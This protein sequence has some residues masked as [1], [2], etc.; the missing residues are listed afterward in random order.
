MGNG[1]IV[2][3]PISAMV[4]IPL[5]HVLVVY[6][7]Q[8]YRLAEPCYCCEHLT[9]VLLKLKLTFNHGQLWRSEKAFNGVSHDAV[10]WNE[11][12]S[13]QF[14]TIAKNLKCFWKIES[15]KHFFDFKEKVMADIVECS[16]KI[17]IMFKMSMVSYKNAL[18]L[19]DKIKINQGWVIFH[20]L[21]KITSFFKF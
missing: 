11:I 4:S 19:I 9:S 6:I 10:T 17:P 8:H 15:W 3:P 13:L 5:T 16:R 14:P 21:K 18:C 2:H 20:S 12:G 7:L 1:V